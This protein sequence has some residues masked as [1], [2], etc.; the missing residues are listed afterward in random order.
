[1]ALQF[2]GTIHPCFKCTPE[3][4]AVVFDCFSLSTALSASKAVLVIVKCRATRSP[5]ALRG[6]EIQKCRIYHV[7]WV[8]LSHTSP[9]PRLSRLLPCVFWS[10][11]IKS[12]L[13]PVRLCDR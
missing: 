5:D 3:V 8:R 12:A 4:I 7:L 6:N 1:M 9:Y 11:T 13:R 2:Y 10:L